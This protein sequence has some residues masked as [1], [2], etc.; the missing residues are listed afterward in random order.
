M[1]SNFLKSAASRGI[2]GA[3]LFAAAMLGCGLTAQ[4]QAQR[5]MGGAGTVP[6]DAAKP[7]SY[8]YLD[9][10]EGQHASA[11]AGKE[12]S[13]NHVGVE[14]HGH[15][16]IDVKNP[17]GTV[18]EHR[19]FE[20]TIQPNG[21]GTLVLLM[22]GFI[23]PSDY[24]IVLSSTGTGPCTAISSNGGA[25]AI[26]RSLTSAPG[27]FLCNNGGGPTYTCSTSLTSSTALNGNTNSGNTF[28]LAGT[29]TANQTGTINSVSAIIGVC[30]TAYYGAGDTTYSTVSPAT[31]NATTNSP[32]GGAIPISAAT[33]TAVNVT[34]SQI[35]Q[36]TVTISFS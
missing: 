11:P 9:P 14:M 18:A 3:A 22:A 6:A 33:I 32:T 20:N 12:D 8:V 23:V 5:S 10:W 21:A 15:W 7:Y 2:F 35:V 26:V 1:I 36:V 25:C 28:T 13:G 4:G 34:A 30:P 29:V 17:D 16:V 31:C 19:D 24:G 27:Y